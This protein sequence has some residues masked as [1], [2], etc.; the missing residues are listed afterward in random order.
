MG[1]S[2]FTQEQITRVRH[3]LE[4]YTGRPQE[5]VTA[6]RELDGALGYLPP[7]ALV[8]TSRALRV[9]ESEVYGVASFYSML[10]LVPRGKHLVRICESAPC[11]VEGGAAL[12]R[13]LL[14]EVGV[15]TGQTTSD[16]LFTLETT[17]CLGHCASGPVLQVDDNLY[18]E[19]TA[20]KMRAILAGY[21]DGKPRDGE[22]IGETVGAL[23]APMEGE[24]RVVLAR[25]G[26]ID[27]DSLEEAR[28]AGAY[29][30]L[31]RVVG[32]M[33]PE[34]VVE[35]VQA[36]GLQ[37]RG[38]A[39]FP[40]GLKWR[41]TAQAA[42]DSKYVVANADESEPG[43]FKDR[44]IMEGDPHLLLEGMAIAGYAIGAHEG[45]IY[46]RG[47]YPQAAARLQLAI[48]EAESAGVLG[49]RVLGH[50]F[51]FHIHVHAGAGAYICGE[52]TALIESLE[53][54]RGEPRVRPPYPPQRGLWDKPTA[55]NNVETLANVPAIILNGAE[56]YRSLGTEH[57]P[58]TKIFL[59]LGDVERRG[60]AEVPMGITVREVIERFGGGVRG[61]RAA[62][63]IQTGGTAG[64]VFPASLL[65]VPLDYASARQG[66]SM[67]S[68]VV[69]VVAEG[70]ACA[71]EFGVSLLRFFRH[72]SCGKCTPCRIGTKRALEL[73][74]GIVAGRGKPEDLEL[75]SGLVEG[76]SE[77]S[78]CGLGQSVAVPL[79]TLL[80]HF[81]E[82][83]REH[84]DQGGCAAL[85]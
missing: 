34:Q 77:A 22:H 61:G 55:V 49:D 73:L 14:E 58:G 24:V 62:V 23:A 50:A 38:G 31:E 59:L 78:F 37:G 60:A 18:F 20:D 40:T 11:H 25:A 3:I 1:K 63:L 43:T 45:Y 27:P 42:G 72:E 33:T 21:R 7:A 65:D 17:S 66:V 26:R 5:L 56:W 82:E 85:R 9:P 48:K 69:L 16:G 81:G 53:G 19:V 8:E 10:S 47:E 44:L 74:E 35:L 12:Y 51:S 29:G 30:A 46:I 28:D 57:S 36:S 13:A 2:D 6:L 83:L 76:F 54:K 64:T 52:E 15:D 75:L 67:G 39:G 80:Q 70:T 79:G 32:E 4:P 71:A 84:I 41:F 68:G